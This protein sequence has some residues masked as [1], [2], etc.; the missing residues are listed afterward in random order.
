MIEVKVLQWSSQNP[1]L[2]RI[3]DAVAE[4]EQFMLKNLPM[5]FIKEEWIIIPPQQI[6]ILTKV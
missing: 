3:R 1:D 6:K 5:C 4:P 2:T